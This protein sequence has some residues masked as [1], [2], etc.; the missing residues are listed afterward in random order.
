MIG[1]IKF[2]FPLVGRGKGISFSE[3]AEKSEN[4]NDL[5][6]DLNNRV[7]ISLKWLIC[8]SHPWST[9]KKLT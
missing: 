2:S 9:N 4:Q 5:W 3:N 7:L 6:T 1:D 8:L